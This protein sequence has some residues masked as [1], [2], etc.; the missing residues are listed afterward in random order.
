MSPLDPKPANQKQ[1]AIMTIWK[2]LS[3]LTLLLSAA[4]LMAACAS[5]TKPRFDTVV[6]LDIMASAE[7][8][9]DQDGRPSPLE[10]QVYQLRD[11][12]Q[13]LRSSFLDLYQNSV[14]VLGGDYVGGSRIQVAPGQID[15]QTLEMS[16][17]VRFLGLVAAFSRY[18]NAK[19]TLVLPVAPDAT[20][21]YRV[22]IDRL[23]LTLDSD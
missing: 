22:R 3:R 6:M 17:E 4:I 20:S 10:I 2:P 8:N 14:T 9:P 5:P 13:F 1:E 23:A 11:A 12:Q 16:S 15:T 18:Q 7:L 19:A 21:K